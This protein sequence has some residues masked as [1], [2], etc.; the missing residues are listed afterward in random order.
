MIVNYVN[1]TFLCR[2]RDRRR[3]RRL[4][5]PNRVLESPASAIILFICIHAN[6]CAGAGAAGAAVSAAA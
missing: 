1:E 6:D 4:A 5:R 2:V 3:R